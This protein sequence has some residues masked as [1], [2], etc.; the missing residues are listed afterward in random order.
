MKNERLLSL[1][2]QM[3]EAGV[4]CMVIPTSDYH[5]SEYVSDFFYGKKIFQ[6]LYRISRNACGN[7]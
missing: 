7:P 1:R 6:R 3:K 2:N 4:H 5:N